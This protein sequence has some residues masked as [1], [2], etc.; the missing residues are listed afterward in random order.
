M[1]GQFW[2]T[3][4]FIG[5]LDPCLKI[6]KIPYYGF[7]MLVLGLT[8]SHTCIYYVCAKFLGKDLLGQC[9]FLSIRYFKRLR[10]LLKPVVT[11]DAVKKILRD[12]RS[13]TYDQMAPNVSR[14]TLHRTYNRA[15]H[16]ALEIFHY[17]YFIWYPCF[18]SQVR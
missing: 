16:F 5:I 17:H 9:I 11:F 18:H 1:D 13:K 3:R 14:E 2:S 12:Q 8:L 7:T 6:F 15:L 4:D 10:D